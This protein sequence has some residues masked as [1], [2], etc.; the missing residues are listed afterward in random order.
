VDSE[1]QTAVMNMLI[2]KLTK[3]QET[4]Y[5]AGL[6]YTWTRHFYDPQAINRGGYI[7]QPGGPLA[8]YLPYDFDWLRNCDRQQPV[9]TGGVYKVTYSWVG[10]PSGH[11]DRDLYA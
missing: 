3:G 2:E 7:E 4:Y 5:L 1:P 9:G 10:G 8:G 6:K 11:W